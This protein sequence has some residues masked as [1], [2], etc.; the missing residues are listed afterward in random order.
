VVDQAHSGS[1]WAARASASSRAV[2]RDAVVIGS[3]VRPFMLLLP[4]RVDGPRGP[5]SEVVGVLGWSPLSAQERFAKYKLFARLMLKCIE[6]T[7]GPFSESAV[8][9]EGLKT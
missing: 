7:C 3:G 9:P 1:S 8:D 2:A 5:G 6:N 4:G